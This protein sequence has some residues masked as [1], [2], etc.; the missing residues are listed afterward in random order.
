MIKK[1]WDLGINF[2]DTAEVYGRGEAEI[3]LGKA[4][5][6]LGVPREDLVISTKV[7]IG[8]G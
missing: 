7:F 5:K 6:A 2:F 1:A 3:Q 8:P 4:L